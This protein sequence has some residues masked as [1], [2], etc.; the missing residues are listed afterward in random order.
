MLVR[1]PTRPKVDQDK[2]REWI[3]R[4]RDCR[5]AAENKPDYSRQLKLLNLANMYESMASEAMN[6]PEQQGNEDTTQ[7]RLRR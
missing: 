7:V 4:A 5:M 3:R 2:I 1:N 6:K